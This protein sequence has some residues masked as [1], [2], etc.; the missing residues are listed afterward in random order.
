MLLYFTDMID[1]AKNLIYK[2]SL[3]K[4][5]FVDKYTNGKKTT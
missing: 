1:G 4:F 2:R 3:S 5:Y